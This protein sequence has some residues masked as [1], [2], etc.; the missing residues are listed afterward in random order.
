MLLSVGRD[1]NSSIEVYGH[2][3]TFWPLT[4]I[5]NT[6]LPTDGTMET[7]VCVFVSWS[8]TA[9]P[10]CRA[11]YGCAQTGIAETESTEVTAK[12]RETGTVFC[13]FLRTLRD[14]R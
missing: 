8:C 5:S 9:S 14:C 4:F 10:F 6:L 2:R 1:L 7:I 3:R 11:E 13:R 12:H